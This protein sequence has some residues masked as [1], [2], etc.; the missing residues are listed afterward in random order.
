MESSKNKHWRLTDNHEFGTLKCLNNMFTKE[1][2]ILTITFQSLLKVIL[3][4]FLFSESWTIGNIIGFELSKSWISTVETDKTAWVLAALF[5]LLIYY[6]YIRN[7]FDE[8][9]L[10]TKSLRFD[11]LLAIIF[12]FA[13]SY[14]YAGPLHGIYY[15][16][17]S[18]L[19][20]LQL[21]L[22]AA[23]P[24]VILI[25]AL[26]REA[27][28][29]LQRKNK[30]ASFFI[31]D[32]EGMFIEDDLLD[33]ADNAAVFAERVYNMGAQDSLVFGIDSPWGTGKSTFVN[34]CIE[35]WRKP[36]YKNKIVIYKFNPLQFTDKSNL[37]QKFVDGLVTTIRKNSFSPEIQPLI[38]DFSREMLKK[39][40]VSFF[41]IELE[42]PRPRKSIDEILK[43]IEEFLS[44]FDKKIIVVIDDLDRLSFSEVK[45][46]LF[47]IK[48]SF[49]LPNISYVLCYDTGNMTDTMK[50]NKDFEKVKE[51]LEKFVNIKYSLLLDSD[52]LKQYVT[53]NF[54]RALRKNPLIDP[55][56]IDRVKLSIDAL[57][58]IFSGQDFHLYQPFVGDIRKLK[59]LINATM[60]FEIEKTDFEN[61]D[62]NKLDL[63]HLLLIYI[64][65]PDI[66]RKIYATE[67]A[68]K[69][70]FFSA[71]I[72]YDKGYP[73][74][75]E[76]QGRKDKNDYMNSTLY[77]AYLKNLSV[78][79]RFLVNKVFRVEQRLT[80]S[81]DIDSVSELEKSTLACFNGN[82]L[83]TG[84]RNLEGYLKLIVSLSKPE[85]SSQHTFYLNCR[86][87]I[88]N[89]ESIDIVLEDE[90]F[91]FLTSENNHEKLWRVI[92][93]T[94][95]ELDSTIS[96]N[97][98]S[99][100]LDHISDYSLF[101]YEEYGLGLRDDL[102][103]FIIKLLDVAGWSDPDGEKGANTEENIKEIA[104]W[105]FGEGR[106]ARKGVLNTL[107]DP[108]RGVLGLYDLLAFRLHCSA[109][110]GGD[111][112]NVTRAIAKHG[113]LNA[114]TEGST[115]K[116]AIEEMR[117]LSQKIFAKF[118]AEYI[119]ST[120]NIFDVIDQVTLNDFT[121]KYFDFLQKLKMEGKISSDDIEKKV[122]ALKMRLK[123]FICYQLGNDFVS[124]GVGCGFYDEEGIGDK[125]GIHKEFNDY[126]FGV[127]FNPALKPQNYNHFL[128]YLLLNYVSAASEDRKRY[129]PKIE[130]FTKVLSK[131]L[132]LDYWRSNRQAIKALNLHESELLAIYKMLDDLVDN[133]ESAE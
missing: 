129:A 120:K 28:S 15:Q 32:Q 47:S 67:T 1:S 60:L 121:G 102:D 13:I 82:T 128:D 6:F 85:K 4:G 132:L 3:Y 122:S 18:G 104:E 91:S 33:H 20:L 12:G 2:S 109:D 45:N 58:D 11:L 75:K 94:A 133:Q 116:I 72:P 29:R 51:F 84:G 21:F 130:G 92:V 79:Q 56:T 9:W 131:D 19:N 39:T 76:S 95:Y 112:F 111:I 93:N 7:L 31:S 70:G 125:K 88:N 101:R 8:L 38:S 114:P 52:K 17:L 110:R 107:G 30:S 126:L 103:Y 71:V 89:G 86:N 61:S 115:V 124:S 55:Y 73:K 63:I 59:R 41:G 96:S 53:D 81:R 46:V 42:L 23:S 64:N 22:L 100:L 34:F 44:N 98:I 57:K 27:H 14:S 37:M 69:R 74:N 118:K 78:Q 24:Y 83:W 127:C 66:F 87:R 90:A 10:I 117:E 50:G 99:Y 68:G 40:K 119:T 25:L 36:E 106:H 35:H 97:L 65:Y 77:T 105:I 5:I 54:D 123:S 80:E 26:I 62:F 16:F 113:N 43:R 108:N 48:K 49:A